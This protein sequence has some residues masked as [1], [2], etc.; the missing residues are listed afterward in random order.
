MKRIV[1]CCDG[2]WNRLDAAYPTNVVKL[3]EAVA[4]TSKDGT[5]QIV[6]Y[7]EGVG[8]GNTAVARTLDRWLGG[9]LGWGL[10]TKVEQAYRFLIFNYDPGDEIYIFGF[11]RGAFTARSLAGLIRNCG[12]IEQPRARRIREAIDFYRSRDP[13]L[14]PDAD[15]SCAF[16]Y[17]L[18][19]SLFLNDDE[20][21]WRSKNHP[22]YDPATSVL[23]QV[24]Y[25][26]VWDTVGALGVPNYLWIA[27][28]FNRKYRFHDAKLS[29][30]V[31]AAR[32]AVAIDERRRTFEPTLWD[33]LDTLNETAASQGRAVPYEQIW[34]PGDHGSVGGGGDIEGLS[35]DA[36][37]WLA[38][39]A[40]EAGLNLRE[41]T[42]AGMRAK[43]DHRASLHN[44]TKNE[45]FGLMSLMSRRARAGP[46]TVAEVSRS[47]YQRW[48][49]G[50][51]ALAE[52][53]LYR[54]AS[55]AHLAAFLD[56][57]KS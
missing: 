50:A 40:A 28:L 41:D 2:T 12:I 53:N 52:M 1:I 10:M 51:E 20:I 35:S 8:T 18:C 33:N 46:K 27:G 42:L 17:E 37:I 15:K 54:P 3:A 34:F 9:G 7:D 25:L 43:I 49:E 19:P 31:A 21:A 26:G 47:T 24:R 4:S 45:G 5:Q 16:R 56:T 11:S 38:E 57:R 55:L 36:F 32:H 44:Q 14:S 30:S 22:P 48:H 39:G 29:R 6:W 13:E 23:L